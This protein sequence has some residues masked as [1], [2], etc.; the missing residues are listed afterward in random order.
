MLIYEVTVRK[1]GTEEWRLNGKFHRENG[2]PAITFANG[3]KH[4]AINNEFHREDGPAIVGGP[5]DGQFWLYGKMLTEEEFFYRTILE[6]EI[7]TDFREVAERHGYT[8][9]RK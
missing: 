4:W 7:I 5:C 6:P 8:L 9:E 2:L 3:I 1:D